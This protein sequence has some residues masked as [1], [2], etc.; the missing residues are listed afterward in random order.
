KPFGHSLESARAL[1]AKIAQVFHEPQVYRIDHYLGKETVQNILVFRFGNS[2]FEPIWNRNFIEY[3]EITAAETLGV[4]HRARYYEE[5][6]AL[7]D[8][9]ANHLLQLLALTAMEPPVAF[10]A[11]SVREEKVQVLRSMRPMSHEEVTTR[12]V[13]GQ[14]GDG[15]LD[16]QNLPAYRAEPNVKPDSRTETYVAIE[17]HIDNWRWAGVPFYVRTGKRLARKVTELVVHLKRT[18]QALFACVPDTHCEPNVIILRIHP[19]EGVAITFGAKK[20]GTEMMMGS[21]QMDFRYSTGFGARPA[22]A[23]ETLLL[24]AMQGDATLYTRRDEVE[25]EWKLIMPIL[26]AW[27]AQTPEFPNY[28]ASTDGPEAAARMLENHGHHW[29]PIKR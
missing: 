25:A 8:M 23:Y 14:Y 1:N 29:R 21:V 19:D 15:Q 7:R 13:R 18:P 11:D 4:E 24:D 16:G 26:E 22:A 6:G 12:T 10:D 9:I 5:A 20:P 28:A 27:G 2:L 17:F 3:V